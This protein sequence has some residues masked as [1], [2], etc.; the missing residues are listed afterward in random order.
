MEEVGRVFDGVDK[1]LEVQQHAYDGD[2]EA[3]AAVARDIKGTG[4][5]HEHAEVK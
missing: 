3:E 1:V 5:T 4:A 2:A